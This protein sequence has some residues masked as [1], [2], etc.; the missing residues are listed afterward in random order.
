MMEDISFDNCN[1]VQMQ[2]ATFALYTANVLHCKV[3]KS[4]GLL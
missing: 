4:R 2:L 1:M 3:H